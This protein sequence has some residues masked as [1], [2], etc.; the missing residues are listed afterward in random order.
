MQV[1]VWKYIPYEGW[2]PED[3]N[4]ED[5]ALG[6]LVKVGLKPVDEM[7]ITTELKLDVKGT[8]KRK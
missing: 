6:Y 2:H 4:N 5:E 8:L 1:T 3:F 7:R